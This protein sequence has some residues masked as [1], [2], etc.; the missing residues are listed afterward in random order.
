MTISN[1]FIKDIYPTPT[2]IP[3]TLIFDNSGGITLQTDGYTHFYDCGAA[4]ATDV[5]LIMQGQDPAEMWLIMQGQDPVKMCWDGD[6]P[7]HY[8]DLNDQ[9]P[10]GYEV[11]KADDV[12]DML[13]D[14]D[15][16]TGMQN[17]KDFFTALK[18]MVK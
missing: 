17:V 12:L 15:G 9:I 4:A 18:A 3:Y 1:P 11:Y 8:I 13:S 5:C 14:F 16:E 2:T 6:E 10:A 7:D